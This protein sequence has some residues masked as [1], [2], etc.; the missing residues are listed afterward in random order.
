MFKK[1][2][3]YIPEKPDFKSF[4]K[5]L[6]SLNPIEFSE[7]LIERISVSG[8]LSGIPFY[9]WR[10]K[11]DYIA[12][13]V[14]W[15]KSADQIKII[16]NLA[17]QYNVPITIR[18]GGTGYYGSSVPSMGDVVLDLK[19]LNKFELNK[20]RNTLTAQAGVN[21]G[22]LVEYLDEENLEIPSISSS[23]LSATIGGWLNT[24]GSIGIG[25]LKHNSFSKHILELKVIS[26]SEGLKHL[27]S[28]EEFNV[29]IGTYGLF[30][31]IIEVTFKLSKKRQKISLLYGFKE[32]TNLVDFIEKFKEKEEIYYLSFFDRNY[33]QKLYD[34][35]NFEYYCLL[36]IENERLREDIQKIISSSN[37]KY[38][39][40]S[41]EDDISNEM[42]QNILKDE[43][44]LKKDIPVLMLQ[45]FLIKIKYTAK[46]LTRFRELSKQRNLNE[47]FIG[48]LGNKNEVRLVLFTFTN[49]DFIVHFLS[50]KGI[51]HRIVKF[52]YQN[53]LGELYDY[54]LYNSIY[55]DKFE[56]KKKE[57]LITQK[58]QYD[59]Q[60]ILNPNKLINSFTSY[61]RINSI[62]ELNLFWRKMAVKLGMEKIFPIFENKVE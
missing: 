26:P 48:V 46:I 39:I 41:I 20:N 13:I 54:G 30:A 31:I 34:T 2:Q 4:K 21:L 18:G 11:E 19:T 27:K 51:L 1:S 16:V 58:K 17:I 40:V 44:R 55:L 22:K 8:D 3:K 36:V 35:A 29:F 32:F 47:G 57:K 7:S 28:P 52:A 45:S 61:R 53:N 38:D 15:P 56:P 14:I 33:F 42:W 10:W 12:R 59:P 37:Q 62:F 6:E 25:T 5:E 49:N 60:Y 23:A 50:S 9:H 43:M 24:K